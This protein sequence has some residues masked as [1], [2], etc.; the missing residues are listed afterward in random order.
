MPVD[1]NITAAAPSPTPQ[2][3]VQAD[4]PTISPSQ[5]EAS[6]THAET[7]PQVT[8]TVD[9]AP[10]VENKA[11]E[12]APVVEKTILGQDHDAEANKDSSEPA[13]EAADTKKSDEALSVEPAP[14]PTYADFNLPEGYV[15]NQE[16]LGKFTKALGEFQNKTGASQEAVQ[17]FGQSLMD[18]YVASLQETNKL[19]QEQQKAKLAQKKAEWKEQFLKDPEIGGNRQETT[20]KSAASAIALSGNLK[21][22]TEFKQLMESTGLG[23]HPAIIRTL[24]RLNDQIMTLKDKYET[25]KAVPIAA[26]KAPPRPKSTS[27]KMY[28]GRGS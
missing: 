21:Q 3:A 19:T 14:L 7:A 5:V 16:S 2:A 8:A 13:K 10:A 18:Q 24:A 27:E 15:F 26:T 6:A 17:E 23:N 11:V 28:G 12:S 25:E 20:V 4:A 1:E 22:Q 9:G